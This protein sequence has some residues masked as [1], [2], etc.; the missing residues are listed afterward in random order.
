ML[1]FVWRLFGYELEKDIIRKHQ[2]A[3]A[4]RWSEDQKVKDAEK[5][6]ENAKP[7]IDNSPKNTATTPI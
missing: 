6:V 4:K 7:S 2:L 1:D 5:V 3:R